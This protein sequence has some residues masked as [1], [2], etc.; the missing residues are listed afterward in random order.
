FENLILNKH[1]DAPFVINL[2]N[3]KMRLIDGNHRFEAVKKYI[4]ANPDNRVEVTLNMYSN[5]NEEIEKELYTQW[6]LG[7]KQSTSDVVKQYK[8]DIPIFKLMEKKDFPVKVNVYGGSGSIK[9][10]S[11]V[12]AYLASI[13]PKFKGGFLASPWEF[14]ARA[15]A[16]GKKD[17]TLMAGF[18]KDFVQAF[19]VLKNNRFLRGTPFTSIMRIWMDNRVTIPYSKM[20]NYFKLRLVNDKIADSLGSISGRGACVHVRGEYLRLLNEGRTKDIFIN[21]D[22][23]DDTEQEEEDDQSEE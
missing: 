1:F 17:V 21:A 8:E 3:G 20:I 12:G 19:G 23:L 10:Y 4:G 9:F 11:L 18:M 15:Q 2:K 7:N 22:I 14:I 13:E 6:N 16:L 5:L